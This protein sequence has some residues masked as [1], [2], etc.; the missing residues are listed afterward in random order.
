MKTKLILV[1]GASVIFFA[2]SAFFSWYEG[3]SLI[4]DSMQWNENAVISQ[5][6][7]GAIVSPD[8]I[9][10]MDFFIHSIKT[11]SVFPVGMVLFFFTFLFGLLLYI[12]KK[13]VTF[14]GI[15]LSAGTLIASS[16][17]TPLE[18]GT[19]TFMWSVILLSVLFAST[20]SYLAY[21]QNK[22]N[23]A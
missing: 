3:S 20:F 6:I 13:A 2:M 9:T 16:F 4:E 1:M 23:I 19:K 8:Q 14:S 5:S 22:E 21:R 18:P 12:H 7:H 10:E 17:L 11:G 15:A